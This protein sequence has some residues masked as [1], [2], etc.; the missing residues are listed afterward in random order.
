M[1]F[2][3]LHPEIKEEFELFDPTPVSAEAEEFSKKSDLK[4]V[5]VLASGEINEENYE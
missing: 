5:P 4:K 1:A 3:D 2:L